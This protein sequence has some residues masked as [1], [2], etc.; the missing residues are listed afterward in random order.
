MNYGFIG[1]GNMASAII[2]GMVGSNLF[3]ASSIY[4]INRSQQKT[5]ALVS[6]YGI[7]SSSTIEELM[8]NV[9]V[10]VLCVKPQIL[11]EVLPVV[12]EYLREGQIVISVAAGKNLDYLQQNLHAETPIF[13][14]MP[15]I[16]AVIGLSTS[17]YSV[18][19]VS[20]QVQKDS[21]E[22][23]FSTIGTIV[24][25]PEN[26]FSIFTTIGCASPA[27]TYLYIDS[28]AR[29]AVREGMPKQMALDIAANSVLG[30]AKMV[31]ESKEHPWSLIDQ[32]CSPGGT[33]IQGVTSLQI[34]HFESTIYDAVDAV[35]SK[36]KA[37]S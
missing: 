11:P 12:K 37:L 6:A 36:D 32:V 34:N 23:L 26:L 7:Q 10:V 19:T 14:V 27:F 4:G 21:V 17:C 1:L 13:R 18:N 28:L 33:T 25:L 35:I 5:D 30:S 16:N 9:D 20:T 8:A 2:K 3:K 29:A 24:E 22:Q 31:L 15:N